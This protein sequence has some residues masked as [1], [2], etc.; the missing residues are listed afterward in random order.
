[1]WVR[2]CLTSCIFLFAFCWQLNASPQTAPADSKPADY[3]KEPFVI[4]K[5]VTK[6]SFENDGTSMLDMTV[7]VRIQSQAGL[8]RFGLLSFPYASANTDLDVVYVRVLKPDQRIVPTPSENI[9]EM[10]ADITRAAPLYS[11]IK[12]KQVAVK[13]LDT[14]DILEYEISWRTHTPMIPGQFWGSDSFIKDAVVLDQEMELRVPQNRYVKMKSPDLQPAVREE[15]AYRVYI[16]KTANLSTKPPEDKSKS[17]GEPETPLPAV[18]FTSFHGWDEIGQ[19]YEGLVAP[20][21]ALTPELKAKAA[22]LTRNS[23]SDSEKLHAIYNY[24][25]TK[26]RYIGI[27]FGIG[28]YQPHTATEIL[29]NEYGDCKDKHT[30]LAALLSAVGI[31][32]YP[33]LINSSAKIDPDIPSPAQFDHVITAVPQGTGFLWLDST[34]EVGPYGYLIASLRDKKALVIPEK[35][36]AELV[37]TPADMPFPS[38]LVFAMKGEL[39]EVGTLDAKAQATVRG[40]VEVLLRAA[41]RQASQSQWKDV[42][43]SV[44]YAWGFSGNVS[45]VTSSSPEDTNSAFHLSYD[46]MRKDYGDWPNKRITPPL[47]AIVLPEAAEESSKSPAPIRLKYWENIASDS[48]VKLPLGLTPILPPQLALKEDFAEYD[49]TYSFSGGVFRAHRSLRIKLKTV[50]AAEMEKYRTFRKAI[51]DD[52]GFFTILV[53]EED[54]SRHPGGENSEAM[55]LLQEG[56]EHARE[57]DPYSALELF[58]RAVSID[59][60][61]AQAWVAMGAVHMMQRDTERGLSEFRKAIDAAP[62]NPIAYRVLAQSLMRLRREDEALSVWRQL[63]KI[64]PTD[65]EAPGAIGRVLVGQKHYSEAVP[66]LEVAVKNYPKNSQ[67]LLFLAQAYIN[68][69]KQDQ[70]V[71]LLLKIPKIDSSPHMLNEVAYELGDRSLR[72]DDALQFAKSS[73]EGHESETSHISLANLAPPDLQRVNELGA[74]WDTLGWVQFR[75]NNLDEAEKYLTAAWNLSQDS[76]VADHLGQAYEKLGKKSEAARLYAL[77]IA[78]GHA[79]DE[80][81]KRLESVLSDKSR[82]DGMILSA[83]SELAHL[84]T[85]KLPRISKQ[86]AVAEFFLLFEPGPTV[87]DVKFISGS[88]ELR[89]AAKTLSATKF[90]VVFPGNDPVKLVRRGILDC[91]PIEAVCEI[92]LLTPDAVQ[93]TN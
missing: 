87:S 49:S 79:P 85:V 32:A 11:D 92:V 25:S 43:Q 56:A 63:E 73:V 51:L 48:E 82:A 19:W 24:V 27:A 68:T 50:P 23:S 41:V 62:E 2:T 28:R 13:G 76:V 57:G 4:E 14:G 81:R 93:S 88:A 47:P 74:A 53:D 46:Y 20:R 33:A 45:E 42:I 91:E 18:Q 36:A 83:R 38:S 39:S 37:N 3:S 17:S 15:K 10:P 8:Q 1:M 55:A 71:E 54:A 40:D 75:R 26:Y 9:Q 5:M 84:R 22:E 58:K 30:L 77:S 65:R 59:P 16:W 67:I 21:L 61:L 90:P 7:R 29:S 6:Q 69:G 35:G 64:D 78:A 86:H 31:K 80:T 52:E 72:L 89:D 44:S 60:K 66:E 34:T 12:E 70:A